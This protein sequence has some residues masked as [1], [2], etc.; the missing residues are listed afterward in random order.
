MVIELRYHINLDICINWFK[1]VNL[2]WNEKQQ[3]M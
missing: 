3:V 1:T 2:D